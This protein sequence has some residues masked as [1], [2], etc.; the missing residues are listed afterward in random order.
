MVAA[1]DRAFITSPERAARVI[2]RAVAADKRRV[3]IGPDGHL[4]NLMAHLSPGIYQRVI[5]AG[6]RLGSRLSV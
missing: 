4:F 2:L 3:I 5:G 6:T 1:S